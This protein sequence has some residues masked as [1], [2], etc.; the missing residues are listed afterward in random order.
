MKKKNLLVMA[1]VV[2]GFIGLCS[3]MA[4]TW[5]TYTNKYITMKYPD[6]YKITDEE[7][8]EDSFDFCCEIKNSDISMVQVSIVKIDGMNELSSSDRDDALRAGVDAM[9]EAVFENE[10]YKNPSCSAVTKVKKGKHSGYA[11]TFTATI[12][13]VDVMGEAFMTIYGNN[14]MATVSQCETASQM[15][16]LNQIVEGIS[17]LSLK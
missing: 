12:M 4:I 9:R 8:G 6:T 2:I 17:F 10:I 7:Q 5:K 16:T 15:K 13:T 1:A 3:F 11:F 14:M